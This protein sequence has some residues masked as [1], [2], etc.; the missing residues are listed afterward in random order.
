MRLADAEKAGK[1]DRGWHRCS[2]RSDS[3]GHRPA[4]DKAA[5]SSTA[6]VKGAPATILAIVRVAHQITRLQI[7]EL[8]DQQQRTIAEALLPMVTIYQRLAVKLH[9]APSDQSR[10]G[11]PV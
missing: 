3:S 11:K 8:S 6:R 4:S 10:A 9:R 1:I 5:S 7:D 2:I